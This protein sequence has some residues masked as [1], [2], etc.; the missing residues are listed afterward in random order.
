MGIRTMNP[1]W[2]GIENLYFLGHGPWFK[3]LV[4]MYN[5]KGLSR[6]KN[7]KE[8]GYNADLLPFD[9]NEETIEGNQTWLF[10]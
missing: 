7:I 1:Q 9:W 10:F 5:L 8:A 6:R 3:E 2:H 4:C